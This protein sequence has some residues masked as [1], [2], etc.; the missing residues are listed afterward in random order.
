[1]SQATS[2]AAVSKERAREGMTRF[3]AVWEQGGLAAVDEIFA[4]YL[5]YH[6]PPFPDMGRD[7]PAA[8]PG[9]RPP[10]T[11]RTPRARTSCTAPATRCPRRGTSA[12]GSAG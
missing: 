8:A 7:D 10:G 4:E 9:S 11:T 3:V 2:P 1:M 5:T 6:G 12:T